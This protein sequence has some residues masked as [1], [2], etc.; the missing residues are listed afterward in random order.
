MGRIRYIFRMAIPMTMPG[1]TSGNI[2]IWSRIQRDLIEARTISQAA[3]NVIA[4]ATVAEV[5]LTVMLFMI[6][7][8]MPLSLNAVT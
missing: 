7:R 1:K 8:I 6:E 4:T 2:A 5:T 3:K